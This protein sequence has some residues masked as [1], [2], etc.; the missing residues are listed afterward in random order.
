MIEFITLSDISENIQV[1]ESDIQFA[2]AYVSKLVEGKNYET[3]DEFLKEL[4][5]IIALERAYLRLSQS[6]ESVYLEKANAYEKLR[7]SMEEKLKKTLSIPTFEL[8][9]RR[10]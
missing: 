5:K 10:A 4:A 8:K 1:E 7:K 3:T 9:I 6:E 2:N